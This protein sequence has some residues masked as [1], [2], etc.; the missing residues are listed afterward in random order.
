MQA[1]AAYLNSLSQAVGK[2]YALPA[3]HVQTVH[4]SVRHNGNAWQG[5]VEVFALMTS[6]EARKCFA[7]RDCQGRAVVLAP[8][9]EITSPEEAVIS[10]YQQNAVERG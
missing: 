2:L 5:D 10:F 7:W 9:P 6:S 8:S 3:L 1:K 4:V